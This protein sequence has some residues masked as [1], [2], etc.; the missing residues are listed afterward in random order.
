[1]NRLDK[2]KEVIKKYF[3]EA[4]CG[5]YFSRNTVGD[6]MSTI[7]CE[8]NITVDVC[9]KWSYFEVLGLKVGEK[10]ELMDFYLQLK[11]VMNE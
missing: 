7:Y 4:D 10:E 2:V 9:H 8:D 6:R 3:E 5:L 1:M 11:E